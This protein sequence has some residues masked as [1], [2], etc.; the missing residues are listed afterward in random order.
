[1]A[2]DREE[3]RAL[4][5]SRKSGDDGKCSNNILLNDIE[6]DDHLHDH[7]FLLKVSIIGS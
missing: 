1:M 2:L 6:S 4:E 3:V 5:E 7:I